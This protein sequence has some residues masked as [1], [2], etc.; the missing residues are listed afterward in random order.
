[1]QDLVGSFNHINSSPL[2]PNANARFGVIISRNGD[3]EKRML[4]GEQI[5]L[6]FP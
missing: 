6:F 4:R 5:W 2:I 3:P 1:M